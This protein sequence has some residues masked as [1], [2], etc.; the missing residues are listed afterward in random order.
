MR[1]LALSLSILL[2]ALTGFSEA[3]TP[4]AT[5]SPA[6]DKQA[7]PPA[8]VSL[9]ELSISLEGLVNRVR[10]SV[11]QIFSTGYVTSDE[12]ET[13][14][15]AALLSTQRSTGS[16]IILSEDGFIVTNA[17]VV[18][19]A[20]RIQVRLTTTRQRS[21]RP[22]VLEPE[23][24]LLEAKL[25]GLDREV[26]VAV[27]KIERKG[28]PHLQLGNSDN[29][30]QGELVMAFGN[31]R[32]LEGSASM[33]IVSSTDRELHPDDF[34]AYIQTDAPINPGNS[35]GP[36]VDAQ[37]RVVGINT[38][39]LSQSGGS[40]GL[41][42]AIPSNMVNAVYTQL[43]KE[44]HVHR[45]RIGIYV[46]TIT[47]PIAEGLGLARDWGV[48]V[49]DVTPD[50]PAE[51]AGVK[52]GD[53]VTSVNGRTMRNARQLE[54][55]VY[56]SPMKEKMTLQVLR[57]PNELTID[58]PV[59]DS[60]DDPERFADMVNP[61]DNLVPKLGILGIGIDKKLAAMLPGLRHEYG[62]VVAAGASATDFTS[63]T[64]LQAGDVIYSV[65]NAP[66]SS[67]EALRMKVDE[68]KT[69]D[70][71]VMQIERSGRLMFV[72]AVIQ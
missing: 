54:S 44:G 11:V 10:P 53:V 55:Y 15:T 22:P 51:Q 27:I 31:P 72:A 50:G 8:P 25:V 63:G 62:V 30:R 2:T 5:Q 12:S 38:F 42:F 29:V 6:Q 69:G 61:E 65:N 56:R 35:G 39:I 19:G 47:P 60:V 13:S 3:Q 18:Q 67:V 23:I 45:G 46:Q 16:G 71:L 1:K 28:L 9:G 33:G 57:G 58:V 21:G 37:G 40:E 64:G 32:G 48:L 66:V 70:E 20:R 26:D 41:G 36:L 34:L 14:N 24:K 49:G 43:R 4:T 68:F 17:H 59:I 7:E 52:A